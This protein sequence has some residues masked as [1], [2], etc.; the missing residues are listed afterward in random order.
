MKPAGGVRREGRIEARHNIGCMWG[1]MNGRN[2]AAT[3]VPA[4]YRRHDAIVRRRR[5]PA[6]GIGVTQF[7][8]SFWPSPGLLASPHGWSPAPL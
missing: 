7:G 6:Y 1:G 5:Q 2:F 3:W 8:E 4:S